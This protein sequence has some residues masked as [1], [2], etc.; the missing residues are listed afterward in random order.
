MLETATS[1]AS[2]PALATERWDLY[3]TLAEP[4]RLRLLALVAEEE[5]AVGELAE[6][7]KESQPNVS[8]AWTPLRDAGLIAARREGTRVFLSVREGAADDVVVGDALK[9]GR[10]LAEKDGSLARVREVVD[11]R[12]Q[13]VRAYFDAPRERDPEALK[14]PPP[15][16]GAYLYGISRFRE[17]TAL[18]AGTGDGGLLDVLCPMFSRVIAVDRSKAQL[19]AAKSRTTL[20]GF[21]NVKFIEGDLHS[22]DVKK[23]VG[24]GVDAVFAVRLLHH[25]AKPADLMKTMAKLLAPGGRIVALDYAKH[26]DEKMREQGDLW[27]GFGESDLRSLAK[28]AGLT[29]ESAKPIAANL[30]PPGPD[31]HLPWESFVFVKNK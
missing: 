8:R 30:V 22:A 10:A 27:L 29:L 4:L 23:V 6:L 21:R 15:E 3:R 13:A 25:A 5:L 31:A 1:T 14:R 9:S 18:D 11:A 16:L 20:R 28:G 12:D 17:E 26:D 7:L 2:S 24:H 19:E